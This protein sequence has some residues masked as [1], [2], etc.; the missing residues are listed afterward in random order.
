[1]SS[2]WPCLICGFA[3]GAFLFNLL[4]WLKDLATGTPIP[5]GITAGALLKAHGLA[6]LTALGPVLFTAAYTSLAA[7][8]TRS[9]V[10]ALVI[11]LVITTV[12]RLFRFFAPMIE[13]YAAGLVDGLYQV[14]PGYHL[15][16][17]AEWLTEGHVLTSPSRR[18]PSRCRRVLRSRS[19]PPGRSVLSC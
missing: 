16:N 4:N 12:E 14:L 7:I 9:T 3:L 17:L 19:L 1:M 10:A 2:L 8:L 11:G 5:A 15:A 13:P 6:F 18:V